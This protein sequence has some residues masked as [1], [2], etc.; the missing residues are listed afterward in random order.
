MQC[1][2]RVNTIGTKRTI[3]LYDERT[4]RATRPKAIVIANLR[5][6]N[7]LPP[8]SNKSR[9]KE[10]SRARTTGPGYLPYT[11]ARCSIAV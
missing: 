8:L 2:S 7:H 9:T 10:P 1:G 5:M 6:W 4:G 11:I 3:I